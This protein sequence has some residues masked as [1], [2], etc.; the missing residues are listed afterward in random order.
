MLERQ[1]DNQKSWDLMK[2]MSVFRDF[3]KDSEA[4]R[5]FVNHNN[6][7]GTAE[8]KLHKSL[9]ID[10]V[11]LSVDHKKFMPELNKNSVIIDK[12][13]QNQLFHGDQQEYTEP[14]NRYELLFEYHKYLL[15]KKQKREEVAE[16]RVL[17]ECTFKPQ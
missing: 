11:E 17:S 12:E 6:S 9:Y 14:I 4:V 3:M 5:M 10:G 2:M 7:T 8:V 15:E 1:R 16:L 13:R